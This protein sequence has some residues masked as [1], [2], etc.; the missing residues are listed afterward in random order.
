LTSTILGKGPRSFS[1]KSFR[2]QAFEGAQDKRQLGSKHF[3]N[4]EKGPS[5]KRMANKKFVKVKLEKDDIFDTKRKLC[6][7]NLCL[8]KL[9]ARGICMARERHLRM[10]P[11]EQPLSLHWLVE[12]EWTQ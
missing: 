11:Q 2:K 10:K 7:G 8:K 4:Q 9:G 1:F 5:A 12:K 3:E 6:C